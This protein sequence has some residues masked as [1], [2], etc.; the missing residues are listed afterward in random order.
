MYKAEHKIEILKL[1]K[2]K[3]SWHYCK[4]KIQNLK[5]CGILFHETGNKVG[6]TTN[7]SNIIK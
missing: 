7:I 4:Q 1:K 5:F 3:K 2:K 6:R